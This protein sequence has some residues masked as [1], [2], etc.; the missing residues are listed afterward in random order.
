M[1]TWFWIIF[2][3]WCFTGLPALFFV[4]A[5]GGP[6]WPTSDTVLPWMASL[7]WMSSPA[8]LYPLGRRPEQYSD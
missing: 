4:M 6:S 5:S 7:L 2:G 3:L 1:R 8:F